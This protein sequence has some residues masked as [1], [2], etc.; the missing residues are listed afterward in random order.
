MY[1]DLKIIFENTH[2]RKITMVNAKPF[3][4]PKKR[5]NP[6]VGHCLEAVA[7]VAL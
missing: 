4:I 2:S 3:M 6:Q 5:R 1:V 7:G